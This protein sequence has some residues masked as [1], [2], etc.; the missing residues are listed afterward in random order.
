ME[1]EAHFED[2]ATGEGK[3]SAIEAVAAFQKGRSW[4]HQNAASTYM[5]SLKVVAMV[6]AKQRRRE[7]QEGVYMVREADLVL[8]DILCWP[9]LCAYERRFGLATYA[10]IDSRDG[11]LQA[12][13]SPNAN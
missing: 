7:L 8:A 4:R 13:P 9:M 1:C 10:Q 11:Q 12:P 6:F 2:I 5:E 3:W